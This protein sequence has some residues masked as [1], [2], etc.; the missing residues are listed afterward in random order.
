M[1]SPEI[2]PASGTLISFPIYDN[3]NIEMFNLSIVFAVFGII[4]NF[5]AI[6][7]S[8]FTMSGFCE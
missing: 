2:Y 8:A 5:Y 3:I 4:H 1:I 6:N 7:M